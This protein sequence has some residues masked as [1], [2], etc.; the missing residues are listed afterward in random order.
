[1]FLLAGAFES[2]E[3]NEFYK[4]HYALKRHWHFILNELLMIADVHNI[5]MND[6]CLIDILVHYHS[7][8]LGPYDFLF[9]F[10]ISILCS[11]RLDLFD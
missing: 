11:P 9:V 7:K 10:D 1:M 8:V 3:M 5:N 4:T 2:E 6:I